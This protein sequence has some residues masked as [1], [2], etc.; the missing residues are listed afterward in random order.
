MAIVCTRS[1][2]GGLM[3]IAMALALTLRTQGTLAA[4][5]KAPM[6]V[7]WFACLQVLRYL[8][9]TTTTYLRRSRGL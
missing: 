8:R 7:H 4:L 2:W 9:G 1:W 3:H 6:Q 5:T